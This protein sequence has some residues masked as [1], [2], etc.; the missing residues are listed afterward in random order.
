MSTAAGPKTIFS[1]IL[2]AI[3][4]SD[5]SMDAA[6]YAISISKQYNAELYAL[7]VIH[8]ADVDLFGATGEM[9]AAAYHTINMNKE[10]Q[11]YLDNVKLKA[12][13]KNIQIKTETIAST[14]TAGGIVDYAEDK[15]IDLIVIG[16]RG[17]SGFK[18]ML[19]G[20]VASKVVTY[21]HCPVLVVK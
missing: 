11:K 18:K 9:S 5:A 10:A 6:D 4:G 20:S 12:S 13:E 3:D 7:H 14:N 2:I 15:D 1:K 8:P 16:T 21:A 17:K 19:L